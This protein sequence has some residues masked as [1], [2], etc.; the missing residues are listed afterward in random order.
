MLPEAVTAAKRELV[1]Q[2]NDLQARL[3]ASEQR[4]KDLE[5]AKQRIKDL[6]T[7][8]KLATTA[9]TEA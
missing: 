7:A 8:L 3:A 2:L 5:E 9:L 6:E 1:D 4:I